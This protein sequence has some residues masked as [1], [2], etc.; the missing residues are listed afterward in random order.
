MN[1]TPASSSAATFLREP[2]PSPQHHEAER[3]PVVVHAEGDPPVTCQVASLHGPLPGVEHDVVPVEQEPDRRHV[4]AAVGTDGGQLCGAGSVRDEP[5]PLFLGH[6]VSHGFHP[7]CPGP[8]RGEGWRG[9]PPDRRGRHTGQT[10]GNIRG[11]HT[12]WGRTRDSTGC[13]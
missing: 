11:R 10:T 1:G 12:T 3:G 7:P 4:R 5:P 9:D 6:L 8:G 2:C 13:W